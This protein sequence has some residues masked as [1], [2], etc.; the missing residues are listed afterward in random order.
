MSGTKTG[1]EK[2][3]TRRERKANARQ[4]SGKKTRRERIDE[5]NVTQGQ[6]ILRKFFSVLEPL[7]HVPAHGNREFF[8]D[9][10]VG[11]LL[12]H[13]YNPMVSSLRAM[14]EATDIESIQ[15]IIGVPKMSLGAMSESAAKVFRAEDLLPIIENVS[16]QVLEASK[17]YSPKQ[18]K[19]LPGMPV[20]VDGTFLKCL[21]KMVWAVFR[22][23]TD[24]RGVRL[25][26]QYDLAGN[27][28][29][30]FEITAANGS[31]PASLKKL[32]QPGLLYLCDRGYIDYAMYQAVHEGGSFFVGRLKSD[33][34]YEVVEDLP[35]SPK[36]RDANVVADQVVAMGSKPTRGRL[37]ARVRR[38]VIRL[39]DKP[40]HDIVLLTNTDLSAEM[41][42]MMYRYR[43]QVELFFKW[44]KCILGGCKHWLSHSETGLTI[45]VYAALLASMLLTLWTGCKPNLSTFRMF[46][47]YLMG[48][49]SEQNVQDAIRRHQAEQARKAAKKAENEA[50]KQAEAAAKAAE[51]L[52][53]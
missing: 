48:W 45:Q 12:I 1:R 19:E 41:V 26:L 50:K 16:G 2:K 23:K 40:G 46:Q 21:P 33:N 52:A 18:F 20:A 3:L 38:V 37:K 25:Q 32:L 9:Q 24:N 51:K 7:R 27:L 44:F 47:W 13:F 17:A 49:A 34:A 14:Q 28:P 31:E 8:F 30:A 43:W 29:R 36:D 6:K 39:P 35:L 10:Y 15:E 53:Q 4:A 11:L 42:A 22:K 5:T